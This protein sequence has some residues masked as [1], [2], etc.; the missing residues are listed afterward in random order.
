MQIDNTLILG[1]QDFNEKE[2]QELIWAGFLAKAIE[3][4]SYD[5]PLI[6]NRCILQQTKNKI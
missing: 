3:Q 6:F 2:S 5:K 4:L 1:D